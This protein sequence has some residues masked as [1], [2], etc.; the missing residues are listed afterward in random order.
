M[1]LSSPRCSRVKRTQSE[2]WAMHAYVSVT[3]AIITAQAIEIQRPMVRL[4]SHVRAKFARS[5][6]AGAS[7]PNHSEFSCSADGRVSP[8]KDR[9]RNFGARGEGPREGYRRWLRAP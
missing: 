2:L 3:K 7:K 5:P 6:K 8:R 1:R 9:H 4:L